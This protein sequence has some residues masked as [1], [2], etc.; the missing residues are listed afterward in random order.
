MS[1]AGTPSPAD[2]VATPPAAASEGQEPKAIPVASAN[3][4]GVGPSQPV[5]IGSNTGPTNI[6][7]EQKNIR[8]HVIAASES[9]ADDLLI[10][11]RVFSPADAEP[12]PVEVAA[13]LENTFV[14][15]PE[16]V[17]KLMRQIEE[18]RVLLLTGERGIG[19]RTAAYYLGLRLGAAMESGQQPLVVEPLERRVAVDLREIAGDSDRFGRRVT[20]FVDAFDQRNRDLYAFF[21]NLNPLKCSKLA[22]TLRKSGSYL[23][24]T[25]ASPTASFRQI[26]TDHI[27]H[28]EWQAP[29]DELIEPALKRALSWMSEQSKVPS[30]RLTILV[31]RSATI[32]AELETLPRMAS[33]IRRFV[34][35]DVAFD[36]ALRSFRDVSYW[37]RTALDRDLE[38]WS[39][40]LTLA[41]AQP[42]RDAEDVA[43]ADFE[44]LRC[45]VMERLRTDPA[46][47]GRQRKSEEGEGDPQPLGHVFSDD[48]LLERCRAVIT[49]DARHLG[50]V[51][52]FSQPSLAGEVWETLLTHHRRVL[53]S[54]LPVL[55]NIAEGE[56]ERD[57]SLRVLA[58]QVIG[59]IGE[60]DPVRMAMPLVSQ[61]TESE[62]RAHRRL[63]GRLA[64][65]AL[66]SGSKKYRDAFLRSVE[67][68]LDVRDLEDDASIKDRLLTAIGTYGQIGI[69]EI[70]HA[71]ERLGAIVT[72]SLV[73]IMSHLHKVERARESVEAQLSGGSNRR[74][75]LHARRL[76][77]SALANQLLAEQAPVLLAVEQTVASLCLI[78]EPMKIL[79]AMGN[80]ISRSGDEAG[81]LVALLFL[82][83]GISDDLQSL[84]AGVRALTGLTGNPLLISLSIT[85]DAVQHFSA[86][87][88]D[89]H[90]SINSTFI[91]SAALQNHLQEKFWDCLTAW[92]RE[93]IAHMDYRAPVE[94]LFVRLATSRRGV[95]RKEMTEALNGPR[96]SESAS[97]RSFAGSIL[98]RLKG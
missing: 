48:S 9:L 63:V 50:D 66:G 89:I 24:I 61:W 47:F 11:Q 28:H 98:N 27:V 26:V 35:D 52:R 46:L 42:A 72:E 71:M 6:I 68:V 77:L 40:V 62:D 36:I 74:G 75:S 90:G 34:R 57:W 64:Q 30:E 81:I 18:R 38:G 15:G 19:K 95:L 31:E 53:M 60:I 78:N 13:E 65:G 4:S 91:L 69:Y 37:L 23:I 56:R 5:A 93:A 22:E 55:R 45:A 54:I 73:P 92:A 2:R 51:V 84:P 33:F 21:G 96:F 94:D 8:N 76:R 79:R 1:E 3:A 14:S 10:H 43:W 32:V 39:F 16:V 29:A 7:N 87:L 41:V 25:A 88:L 67:M 44:R 58:A 17:E 49:K 70:Q 86:F 97:M 12:L 20:V 59:R 85:R 80:W 82:S 83:D